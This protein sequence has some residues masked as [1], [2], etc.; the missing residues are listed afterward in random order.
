MSYENS[1]EKLKFTYCDCVK[2]KKEEG[3]LESLS[4]ILS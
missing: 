3:I 2:E 4:S 1:G